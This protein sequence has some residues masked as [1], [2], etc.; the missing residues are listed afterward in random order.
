MFR[1]ML[2][3]IEHF[4]FD[5]SNRCYLDNVFS[6]NYFPVE[7]ICLEQ[8]APLQALTDDTLDHLFSVL[9]PRIYGSIIDTKAAFDQILVEAYKSQIEH[10]GGRMEP[11]SLEQMAS[12]LLHKAVMTE[13]VHWGHMVDLYNNSTADQ[14][15]AI[16]QFFL[17]GFNRQLDVILATPAPDVTLPESVRKAFD[18]KTENGQTVYYS[19]VEQQW[20]N[21]VALQQIYSVTAK[22][23][24]SSNPEVLVATAATLDEVIAFATIYAQ[25]KHPL[26]PLD[27]ITI[28]H[29][30]DEIAFADVLISSKDPE[31]TFPDGVKF[32]LAWDLNKIGTSTTNLKAFRDDLVADLERCE[33]ELRDELEQKHREMCR[34]IHSCSS[35][36]PEAFTRALLLAE[37]ALGV[38]WSKVNLLEDALGL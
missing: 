19:E 26:S 37:R 10:N 16:H 35:D 20:L 32:K 24:G 12:Y 6:Q 28:R 34:L 13:P 21:E 25:E 11:C 29:N 30:N 14:Q 18:A 33:P 4:P 36:T 31:K 15:E 22:K 2:L 3:G 27:R 17:H 9:K 1:S 8:M 7:S 38:Q 5:V 23:N